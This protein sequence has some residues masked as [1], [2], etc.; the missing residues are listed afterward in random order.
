MAMQKWTL[1]EGTLLA[2]VMLINVIDGLDLQLMPLSLAAIGADWAVE[3]GR[4]SAAMSASFAGQALGTAVG[5]WL[6]DRWGRKP[7]ILS[8]MLLFGLMTMVMAICTNPEQLFFA[9]LIGGL[10]Y[11]IV[12]PPMLAMVVESVA[13]GRRGPAVALVMLSMP[14]GIMLAG[15]AIPRLNLLWDWNTTFLI[16]GAAVFVVVAIGQLTFPSRN[17]SSQAAV[18]A[19][20]AAPAVGRRHMIGK[21]LSNGGAA[22]V[23]SLAG[24]MCLAYIVMAIILS[25]LPSFAQNHVSGAIAAGQ[26]I[27][28]WSLSGMAGTIAAGVAVSRFGEERAAKLI[29]AGL[30]VATF[31]SSLVFM[32]LGA[33][34]ATLYGTSAVCGLFSNAAITVL[35]SVASTRFAEDVRATGIAVVS[36]GGKTGG[37]IGGAIGFLVLLLPSMAGFFALLGGVALAALLGLMFGLRSRPIDA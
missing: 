26:A 9:R 10:G 22:A 4:F 2:T 36:L 20:P 3:P 28:I 30:T 37:M 8:G 24:G 6:G 25:W 18:P 35:Y 15:A 14:L 23:A 7:A 34:D 31:S 21:L 16:C 19:V 11:G 1:R 33:S 13:P 32:A 17:T 29:L 27:S 12:L 5:G